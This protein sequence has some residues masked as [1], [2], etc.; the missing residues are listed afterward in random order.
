MKFFFDLEMNSLIITLLVT[1][2]KIL[3]NLNTIVYLLHKISVIYRNSGNLLRFYETRSY[4]GKN[5]IV[6]TIRYK[7]RIR[8]NQIFENIAERT[9]FMYAADSVIMLQNRPIIGA[10]TYPNGIAN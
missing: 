5:N 1:C 4:D 7:I 3:T 6:I 2:K 8:V 10:L 9:V